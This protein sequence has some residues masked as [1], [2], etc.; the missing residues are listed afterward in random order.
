MQPTTIRLPDEVL[1]EVDDEAKDR[2][3]SRSDYIRELIENRH[4]Y[5][6]LQDDYEDQLRDYEETIERLQN[7]KRLILEQREEHT[8]L[9]EYVEEERSMQRRREDRE[10]RRAEAGV[11]TRAKWWLTGMPEDDG[12]DNERR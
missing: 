4:D 9:V 5:A 6:R 2:G 3:L 8:D 11:L 1:T 10:Q 7:E 12:G